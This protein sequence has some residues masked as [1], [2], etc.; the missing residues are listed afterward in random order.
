MIP[1]TEAA[2]LAAPAGEAP[3]ASVDTR[4]RRQQWEARAIALAERKHT[5]HT[6]RHIGI[7]NLGAQLYQVPS[8][9]HD[10][11]HLVT[12]AMRGQA[13]VCDC[14][15]GNWGK[16]CAHA[17]AAIIAERQRTRVET[18]PS[19]AWAWWMNGGEWGDE[20]LQK[21]GDRS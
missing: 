16:S 7:N 2:A 10:G 9:R 6:A 13:V 4:Q 8:R 3:A 17:G 12:V 1:A 19:E 11:C 15:A 5:L 21:R 18:G 20:D 14:A